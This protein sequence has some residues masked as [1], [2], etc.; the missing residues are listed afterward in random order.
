MERVTFI[1]GDLVN[2][3][4]EIELVYKPK[5]KPSTRP[6]VRDSK[7]LYQLLL[8]HWDASNIELFEQFKAVLLNRASR[9][10]GIIR[11]STG[12]MDATV[13]DPRLLFGAALKAAACSIVVAHNHPSGN[14]KPSKQDEVMTQKLTAAG[15][16]LDIN[17][18]DHII[19]TPD[20]YY[21]FADNGQL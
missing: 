8:Q 17:V 9:V 11:I 7:E 6:Q 14:L 10:L 13:V 15:R 3:V 21:S 5:V 2:N 16:L 19:I 20:G 4:A 12:S 18:L 1:D